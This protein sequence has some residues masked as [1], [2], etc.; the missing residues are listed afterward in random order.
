MPKTLGLTVRNTEIDDVILPKWDFYIY[1]Y[2]Y[3]V[4]L[5]YMILFRC[6]CVQFPVSF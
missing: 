2:F 4:C 1:L 3:H 5:I 6:V